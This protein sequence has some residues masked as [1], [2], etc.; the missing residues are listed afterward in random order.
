[1]SEDSNSNATQVCE[2]LIAQQEAELHAAMHHVDNRL[3]SLDEARIRCQLIRHPG[4]PHDRETFVIDGKPMVEFYPMV[5]ST[6]VRGDRIV[7][8]ASRPFRRLYP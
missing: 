2:S 8:L 6:E 4:Q 3:W 7:L 5:T 1:M